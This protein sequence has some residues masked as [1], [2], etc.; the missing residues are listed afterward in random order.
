MRRYYTLVAIRT[1]AADHPGAPADLIA[2]ANWPS[3]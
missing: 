2:I 1:I 3:T